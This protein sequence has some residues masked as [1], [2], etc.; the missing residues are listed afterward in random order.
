MS[1]DP[2]DTGLLADALVA[3]HNGIPRDLL[4]TYLGEIVNWNNRVGLVSRRSTKT[5]LERLVSQSVGLW[6]LVA[7]QCD[8][9]PSSYVDVGT[10]AGFPGVIWKMLAPGTSG[11]LVERREKKAT[12][13]DRVTRVLGF[14]DLEVFSGD[15]RDASQR[16]GWKGAFEL[17]TTLA[18]ATPDETIPLVRP[19]L[20]PAGLFATI[21]G[22]S[23]SAPRE[24]AGMQLLCDEPHRGGTL[25]VYGDR[26]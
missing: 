22:S 5:V 14:G 24:A 19:F 2:I 3:K 12:F 20:S 1:I 6:D 15:A 8:A 26:R 11:L 16:P 23:T 4:S 25:S 9:T 13:L 18:V 10:G 7:S 21:V 17:A